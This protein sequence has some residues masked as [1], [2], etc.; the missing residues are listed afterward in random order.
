MAGDRS[1][2]EFERG[3][4]QVTRY[5]LIRQP[6]DTDARIMNNDTGA[7][8]ALQHHE[9][10]EVPV[11]DRRRLE[12][13]E[14]VELEPKRT[15]GKAEPLGDLHDVLELRALERDGVAPSQLAK[16]ECVAM[17]AA[18]HREAG[19]TAFGGFGLQ[20]HR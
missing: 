8:G 19:E 4:G 10:A 18:D 2:R 1:G 6:P 13:G 7:I 11:Q 3:A 16:V 20:D 15:R 12:K 9:M 5:F 14:L 17:K